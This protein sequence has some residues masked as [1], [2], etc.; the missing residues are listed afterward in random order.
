MKRQGAAGLHTDRQRTINEDMCSY[1]LGN[2]CNMVRVD[3]DVQE[4]CLRS[5]FWSLRPDN[6][7]SA[8]VFSA[9]ALLI[10]NTLPPSNDYF[11][12]TLYSVIQQPLPMLAVGWDYYD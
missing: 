8:A 2:R 3:I 10:D 12:D 4:L 5:A 9:C 11:S 6:G 1:S 7:G